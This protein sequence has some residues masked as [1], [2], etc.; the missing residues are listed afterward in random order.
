MRAGAIWSAGYSGE[1]RGLDRSH[2]ARTDHAGTI[3]A[4]P[5]YPSWAP[6]WLAQAALPMMKQQGYGRIVLTSSGIGLWTE[7]E[8]P[9]LSGYAIGK[10]AQLGLM[11]ARSEEHTS[12]LQSR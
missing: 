11:N 2:S 1:Q 8:R 7:G 12:E 9:E 10:A 3:H 6:L 4:Y 5:R